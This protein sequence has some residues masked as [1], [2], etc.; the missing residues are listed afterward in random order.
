VQ[1]CECC[2]AV[3]ISRAAIVC[4]I[5]LQTLICAIMYISTLINERNDALTPKI[6]TR[7]RDQCAQTKTWN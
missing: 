7:P 2:V 3:D 1:Q 4:G 6:A 5:L